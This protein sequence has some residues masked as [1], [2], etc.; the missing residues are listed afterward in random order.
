MASAKGIFIT[1]NEKDMVICLSAI[2]K[3]IFGTLRKMRNEP[4][5]LT[6]QEPL[7]I[8]ISQNASL[9]QKQ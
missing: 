5:Q 3:M 9:G 6:E 1:G 8:T 2:A 4:P 7:L